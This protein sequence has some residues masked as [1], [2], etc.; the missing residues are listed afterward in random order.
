MTQD[1]GRCGIQ[2]S[3]LILRVATFNG[4]SLTALHFI[5]D[6]T[7]PATPEGFRTGLGPRFLGSNQSA[8]YLTQ[9]QPRLRFVPYLYAAISQQW[10]AVFNVITI[11]YITE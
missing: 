2:P 3:S 8:P 11:P 4:R 6:S 7:Q 1:A 10:S 9:H 5:G